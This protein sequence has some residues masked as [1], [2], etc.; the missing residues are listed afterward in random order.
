MFCNQHIIDQ[1]DIFMRLWLWSIM[2]LSKVDKMIVEHSDVL[3][4]I[5]FALVCSKNI[6]NLSYNGISWY[7]Y[8]SIKAAKY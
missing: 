4:S 2:L 6:Q 1:K 3:V 7:L 5:W 8:K